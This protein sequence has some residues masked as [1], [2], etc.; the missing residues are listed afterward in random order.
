MIP[1]GFVQRLGG[2]LIIQLKHPTPHPLE[3]RVNLGTVHARLTWWLFKM[4]AKPILKAG[5]RQN[6]PEI[7]LSR[8]RHGLFDLNPPGRTLRIKH[9][10][11]TITPAGVRLKGRFA[12]EGFPDD[13]NRIATL[14]ALDFRVFRDYSGWRLSFAQWK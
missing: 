14:P 3:I 12:L 10:K 7:I 2:L 13:S 11:D 4:A 1:Q 5:T 8:K 6:D 9:N